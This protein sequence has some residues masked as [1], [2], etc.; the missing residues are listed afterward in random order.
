MSLARTAKITAAAIAALCLATGLS[1]C[2]NSDA[3]DEKPT[4]TVTETVTAS[5]DNNGNTT[6]DNTNRDGAN[7]KT[8]ENPD[9]VGFENSRD[10]CIPKLEESYG[11]GAFEV[12][13]DAPIVS[14]D[15]GGSVYLI[16]AK[17]A[18][19]GQE[20]VFICKTKGAGE[21]TQVLVAKSEKHH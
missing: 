1:A 8:E 12:N 20:T 14:K 10:A 19:N 15:T 16:K 5:P 4:E 17:G 9:A 21:S 7:S 11:K 2:G 18:V 6:D 3:S 13:W